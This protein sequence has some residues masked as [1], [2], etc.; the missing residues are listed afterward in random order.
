MSS[1]RRALIDNPE[2]ID[3]DP[4]PVTHSIRARLESVFREVFDDDALQL[5]DSLDRDA[6]AAWDSLGHIRLV[7]A[8]EEAFGIT[9]TL[10]EIESMTSV[11]QVLALVASRN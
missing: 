2:S 11:P 6:L 1:T 4:L 7:T 5:V 9:F 8:V 3:P 10:D